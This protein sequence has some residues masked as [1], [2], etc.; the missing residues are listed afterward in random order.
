[1]DTVFILCFSQVYNVVDYNKSV[2][3]H[4]TYKLQKSNTLLNVLSL[5]SDQL[6]SHLSTLHPTLS[7]IYFSVINVSS[8]APLF[9]SGCMTIFQASYSLTAPDCMKQTYQRY[10]L[11]YSTFVTHYVDTEK[12]QENEES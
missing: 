12:E 5:R 11:K 6:Y 1:M 4:A 7:N 10:K 2:I 9:F 8:S 3:S